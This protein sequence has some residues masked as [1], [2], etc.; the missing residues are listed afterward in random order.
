MQKP[1]IPGLFS[2]PFPRGTAVT[3]RV[4][5]ETDCNN[6]PFALLHF[7]TKNSPSM[8]KGIVYGLF[9]AAGLA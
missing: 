3:P 7:H 9:A 2:C 5:R 6:F 8:D 4:F 1:G